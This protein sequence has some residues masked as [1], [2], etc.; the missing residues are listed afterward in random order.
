MPSVKL[1][2]MEESVTRA[3]NAVLLGIVAT[4]VAGWALV[5]VGAAR[6]AGA[7]KGIAPQADHL[8][9]QMTDYLASLTSFKVRSSAVDEVVTAGGQKIQIVSESDVAV[10]RP[11]RLRSEQ[12]GAENGLAFFYD[13]VTM[14]LACKANRTFASVPAPATIDETIDKTRKQFHLEA[15]GADLLFSHP[16]D[17][18]TEQV[19]QGQLIGRE[20]VD[21][22]AA[23]HLAFQGEE[24][25]WQIWIADS[26]HPLPLRFVITSK[27]EKGTPEF[28]VR[29]TKWEPQATLGAGMFE[30]QAPAGASKVQSFPAA[31]GPTASR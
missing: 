3:R 11:N 1:S 2:P 28:A 24:V 17:I 26:G 15:P 16:Y 18:L 19:T 22:Q 4:A 29:L 14:T 9:R 13:G 27:K 20:T 30:Y 21:G 6:A 5:G 31:C 7:K 12:V 10:A 23:N 25:D 8:L